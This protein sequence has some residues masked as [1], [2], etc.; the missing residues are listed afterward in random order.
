VLQNLT[1]AASIDGYE[2]VPASNETAMKQAVAMQ[3]VSIGLSADMLQSYTHVRPK[4]I[5]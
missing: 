2:I 5:R 1:F 4:L 3:P